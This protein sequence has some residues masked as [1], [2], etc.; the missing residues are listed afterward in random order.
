MFH[1]VSFQT[2]SNDAAALSVHSLRKPVIFLHSLTPHLETTPTQL[3]VLHGQ[4][5]HKIRIFCMKFDH[6]SLRK[7]FIFVATVP[8][9]VRF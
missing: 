8:P 5:L 6:L 9:D 2:F 4:I 7:I 3:S 1:C